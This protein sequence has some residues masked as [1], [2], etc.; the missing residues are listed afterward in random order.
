MQLALS[1]MARD[2][3]TLGTLHYRFPQAAQAPS[4]VQL[5]AGAWGKGW[6]ARGK[7]WVNYNDLIATSLESWLVRGIIPTFPYFRLVNYY[8]LPR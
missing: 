3:G 7:I 8:N 1:A 4:L 2:V 6:V 5:K